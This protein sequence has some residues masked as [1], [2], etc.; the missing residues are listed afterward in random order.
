M[1][2]FI[3]YHK[4]DLDGYLGGYILKNHILKETSKVIEGSEKDGKKLD[5]SAIHLLNRNDD[6]VWEKINEYDIS[7]VACPY[8]YRDNLDKDIEMIKGLKKEGKSVV[9]YFVD[10]CPYGN[11]NYFE[12]FYDSLYFGKH[13]I[14]IDHHKTAMK[15]I[16][17][18]EEE[19]RVT[20]NK[21]LSEYHSGCELAWMYCELGN[22]KEKENIYEKKMP[23]IINLAG[24]YD[25]YRKISDYDWDNEV[26]P[27]QYWLRTEVPDLNDI[28]SSNEI[29]D[30]FLSGSESKENL[31]AA[32]KQGKSILTYLK[33]R[34]KKIFD[35]TGG[36]YK[37]EF[38]TNKGILKHVCRIVTDYFNNSSVFSDNGV[39]DDPNTVYMI[40]SANP[41]SKKMYKFSLYSI[42]GSSID[43]S[44]IASAMGGGGHAHAAGFEAAY[45][46]LYNI[47]AN[48][49]G[50]CIPSNADN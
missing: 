26:L 14:I 31:L 39:Y 17:N 23:A 35:S 13:F 15:Y 45:I 29:V 48:E 33:N 42:E 44:E 43:V 36:V 50:L 21:S 10:C 38:I 25:T 46:S 49:E 3:Y 2:T 32:Y 40:I 24:I 22:L 16:A 37:T 5:S 41:F 34:N 4:A 8:N 20:I 11:E 9:V 18:F 30:Y 19:N 47:D 1:T 28:I 7:L 12:K 27:F 6:L